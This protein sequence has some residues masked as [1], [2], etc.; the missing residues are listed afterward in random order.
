[1]D[2]NSSLS[3]ISKPLFDISASLLTTRH[4]HY[5]PA[6]YHSLLDMESSAWQLMTY[7]VLLW[8]VIESFF[9][10][11]YVAT[12]NRLQTTTKAALTTT[13]EQRKQIYKACF[14]TVDDLEA[15]SVGWF[16]HKHDMSHPPFNRIHRQNI[17]LW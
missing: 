12:H 15:W 17:A 11:H 6:I 4:H 5:S 16:Y 9:Y 14:D 13:D 1:M 8:T 7:M 10:M 2:V 3:A